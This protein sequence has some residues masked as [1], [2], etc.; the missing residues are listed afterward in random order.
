MPSGHG[1]G[2][3]TE[4]DC[5]G[6]GGRPVGNGHDGD[7]GRPPEVVKLEDEAGRSEVVVREAEAGQPE[8]RGPK[9]GG[10]YL[11]DIMQ[12]LTIHTIRFC[13]ILNLR[14]FCPNTT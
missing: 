7:G 11:L 10:L 5:A 1:R 6:G 13:T 2:R 3:P 8:R 9:A 12:T 14:Y 4:D